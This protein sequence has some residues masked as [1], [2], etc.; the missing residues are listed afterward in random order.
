MLPEDVVLSKGSTV[1][2]LQNMYRLFF[3]LVPQ[4]NIL[5]AF[6]EQQATVHLATM[7]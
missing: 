3:A 6:T 5:N 1:W 4:T 7:Y 2:E